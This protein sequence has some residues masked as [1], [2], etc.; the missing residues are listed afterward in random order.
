V[1]NTQHS[2]KGESLWTSTG[3][4]PQS[5]TLNLGKGYDNIDMLEYLPQR[6]TGTTA[7]NVTSYKVYVSTDN[8]AFT[9][10]ASG[11][12]RLIPPTTG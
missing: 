2:S 11:R 9:Q 10:V 12:G 8:V 7:G 5:V 1:N 6:N 3:A 4:L